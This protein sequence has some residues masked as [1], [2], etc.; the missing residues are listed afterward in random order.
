MGDEG[1]LKQAAFRAVVKDDVQSLTSVLEGLP[2]AVWGAWRN[3]AGKDLLELSQERGSANAYSA[4]AK[5]LGL[6]TELPRDFFEERETVWVY[7][8]G[9]VQPRRATVMEDTPA[10][11]DTVLVEYWDGDEPATHLDRC[12]LRKMNV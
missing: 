2:T 6:V 12:M 1:V 8:P 10:E 3:R 4:L 9:D 11:A 5:G 7:I